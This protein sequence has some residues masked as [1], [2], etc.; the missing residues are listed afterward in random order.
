MATVATARAALD[1]IGLG[2]GELSYLAEGLSSDAWLIEERGTRLVLRISKS[3]ER[4]EELI[5]EH[6]VLAALT[7]VGAH[8]PAPVAGSWEH[9]DWSGPAFSVITFIAG[10]PLTPKDVM[11]IAD[12]IARFL[13]VL[14]STAP[15]QK[16]PSL[17]ER[18]A[19]A[20]IWPIHRTNLSGHPVEVDRHTVARLDNVARDVR[21]VLSGAQVLVHSDLHEEN[22]LRTETGAAFL[23]FGCAFMGVAQWDFAALAFFLGWAITERVLATGALKSSY[24]VRLVALSFALYRWE[25]SSGDTE[26]AQ[27]CAAFIEETLDLA[28]GN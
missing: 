23:D 19:G 7:A 6:A 28:N 12:D 27:H 11:A 25:S 21:R 24:D 4:L 9:S 14:H 2:H 10:E 13:D 3:E 15:P 26:E 20:P 8:V 16:M 1:T 17:A 22:I 18:F 5:R